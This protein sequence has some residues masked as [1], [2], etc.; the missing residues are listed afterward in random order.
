MADIGRE[1]SGFLLRRLFETLMSEDD[2]LAAQEALRRLEEAI[3]ITEFEASDYPSGGRRF[4]KIVRFGTISLVKAG[5]MTKQKGVWRI[6]TEGSEA[7]SKYQD[8]IAFK[9]EAYK[10]Y[11]RWKADQPVDVPDDDGDSEQPSS[12][13]TFEEA[14]EAAWREISG[15]LSAINPYV[16]QDMV[17]ALV[18]ALGYYVSFIAPPGKDGGVDIIA[19]TDPLGTKVPRIKVQV[20]R[21]ADRIPVGEVRSFLAVLADDD[22]GLFVTTGG[23]TSDAEA[24]VRQ[25]TARTL[26]LIDQARFVELWQENYDKLPDSAR[27]QFPM[28]P[29]HFLAPDD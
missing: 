13:V 24:E 3:E 19:W 23:F 28:R 25:Q 11:K 14:E 22:V 1:R 18:E 8:P 10:L 16:F 17:A 5:W 12:T 21:R 4:E 6:T 9:R 15:F 26:T 7:W 2:G 20:K 29:I 27:K